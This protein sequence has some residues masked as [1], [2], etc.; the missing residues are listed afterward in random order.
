MNLDDSAIATASLL[1]ANGDF[2]GALMILDHLL[3]DKENAEALLLKVKIFAQQQKY[4]EAIA[5][6]EK[7]VEKNPGHD[8]ANQ[9]LKKLKYQKE[10]P[11]A[12]RKASRF[13]RYLIVCGQ[14]L[15][16]LIIFLFVGFFVG[17]N[18][19]QQDFIQLS[20]EIRAITSDQNLEQAKIKTELAGIRDENMSIL[21]AI[22]TDLEKAVKKQEEQ[23]IR[24]SK[25]IDTIETVSLTSLYDQ[26]HSYVQESN[27]VIKMVVANAEETRERNA[28]KQTKMLFK[29]IADHESSFKVYISETLHHQET[30]ALEQIE[31]MKLMIKDQSI[32]L[33]EQVEALKQFVREQNENVQDQ[34]TQIKDE[35]SEDNTSFSIW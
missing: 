17:R 13:S 3:D 7:I 35:N 18:A 22:Q 20:Q 28:N 34:I 30:S 31:S 33:Q 5:C 15:S 9:C 6:C 10:M 1:A 24:L 12:L 8:Q 4:F 16:V 11:R 19:V 25:A 21:M 23:E 26:F 2:D 32:Y 29:K 14:F 27:S